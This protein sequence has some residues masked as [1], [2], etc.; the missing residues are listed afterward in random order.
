MSDRRLRPV[1]AVFRRRLLPAAA[2]LA[3]LLPL[4]AVRAWSGSIHRAVTIRA[5][6]SAP[7]REMGAFRDWAWCLGYPSACPDL[8]RMSDRDAEAP[9]HWFET[10]RFPGGRIP[11]GLAACTN[12]AD[13][14]ALAGIPRDALGDAP[15]ATLVLLGWMTDAMRT[16]DWIR[17][18]RCAATLSHYVADL[19]QPL[20]CTRNFNGQE[21][22]QHGVHT[23]FET[24]LPAKFFDRRGLRAARPR[25]IA[26]PLPELVEWGR[27]STELVP[28]VLAADL[29]A[30]RAAGGIPGAP[31][32]YEFLWDATGHIVSN[33]LNEAATRIASLY[34]TAWI[35][36]GRPAIPAPPEEIPTDSIWSG[37]AADPEVEAARRA[38]R[39]APQRRLLLVVA[40]GAI[41]AF[42]LLLAFRTVAN[43]RAKAR[44]RRK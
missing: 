27:Q 11:P 20:H 15:W 4:P 28:E 38:A 36:A 5:A 21:T 33:R 6:R 39:T 7:Y 42:F 3:L 35:D 43:E 1:P 25:Y 32:Y 2:A 24:D 44:I 37:V 30:T 22:G 26:D 31:G 13:A 10:D 9:R 18:A 14:F 41:G 29:D 8:W 19:H 17:A 40:A 34:Y 12:E 16:N 23:R